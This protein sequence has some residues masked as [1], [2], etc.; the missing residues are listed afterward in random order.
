MDMILNFYTNTSEIRKIKKNIG[1]VIFSADAEIFEDCS[2][3]ECRFRLAYNSIIAAC[4][5]VHVPSLNRYY[6]IRDVIFTNAGQMIVTCFIDVL[7]SY[8]NQI[9]S[10]DLLVSKYEYAGLSTIPDTNII[11][12]DYNIINVY[13]SNKSFDTRFGNYVLEIYGG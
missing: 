5:Y 8:K 9:L 4:N 3:N 2:I 6:Y 1:S 13:N 12:K 7:M 10:K 11:I